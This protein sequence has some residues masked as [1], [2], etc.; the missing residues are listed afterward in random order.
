MWII[1][2][3]SIPWDSVTYLFE[4]QLLSMITNLEIPSTWSVP[5]QIAKP[6]VPCKDSA[7]WRIKHH[8]AGP[9]IFSQ[10]SLWRLLPLVEFWKKSLWI[11][12]W[13][14][15]TIYVFPLMGSSFMHCL[16]SFISSKMHGTSNQLHSAR[17]IN[18]KKTHQQSIM[19]PGPWSSKLWTFKGPMIDKS[20]SSSALLTVGTS[21]RKGPSCHMDPQLSLLQ[22]TCWKKNTEK[23][24]PDG[25]PKS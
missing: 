7:R 15:V 14:V 12:F 17:Y 5:F 2:E 20:P 25:S 13:G 24:Q 6:Q 11:Y 3:R 16:M 4:D 19:K 22:K 9:A 18:N 1:P 10:W 8:R 23:T 21:K